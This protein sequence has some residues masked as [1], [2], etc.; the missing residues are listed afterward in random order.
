MGY[1]SDNELP[2][3]HAN[4]DSF[5]RLPASDPGHQ[6]AERWMQDHHA[7]APT[8]SLRSEF[9]EFGTEAVRGSGS[10]M[11]LHPALGGLMA[12]I[13]RWQTEEA[14]KVGMCEWKLIVRE[15]THE[16]RVV[17][18]RARAGGDVFVGEA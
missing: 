6:A 3:A 11:V 14:V 16:V 8:D 7:T 18:V 12:G 10:V 5:L 1:F 9:L 13:A 4:L 15:I 17:A 2:F